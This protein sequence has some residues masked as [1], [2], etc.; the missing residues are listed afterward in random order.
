MLRRKFTLLFL[1]GTWIEEELPVESGM[2][3]KLP[4]KQ[5]YFRH[6][7]GCVLRRSGY[8]KGM[9]VYEEVDE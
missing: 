4:D 9:P 2:P 3:D 5:D 8:R 7:Q 1:D 6:G